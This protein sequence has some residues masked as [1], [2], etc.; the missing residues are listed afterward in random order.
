[1]GDEELCTILSDYFMDIEQGEVD[2]RYVNLKCYDTSN[3]EDIFF[4][5]YPWFSDEGREYNPKLWE[6]KETLRCMDITYSKYFSRM[7][8]FVIIDQYKIENKRNIQ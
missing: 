2:V 1:M 8:V 6:F 5:V 7:S 4:E 3:E